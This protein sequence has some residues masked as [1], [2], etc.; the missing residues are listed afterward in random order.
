METILKDIRFGARM[1]V[2]NPG[3]TAIAVIALTLGIGLTTTMFS[4][5][6]GALLK[7]LPFEEADRVMHLE[8]NNL[9]Q[10]IESMEVTIHD[11]LDW[12]EQQGSFVDI[13]AFYQGTANIS[14]TEGRPERYDGAFIT[15]S[16]FP[17]LRV[18]PLLGRVFEEG[19]HS[20]DAEPVVLIGYAMW[21]NRFD[22]DPDIVGKT[23]LV[24]SET[25][26]IIG[27]MPEGFEFPILE[28]LW[29]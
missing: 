26:T 23:A 27:V 3:L 1:L 4:I 12:R 24:N 18:R 29:M 5:V 22:S 21:Q 7:G 16:A 10:D 17:W 9:S 14:G 6:N 13:A 15:A 19:E 25:M 20:P 11:Y 28:D 8:R 2:K